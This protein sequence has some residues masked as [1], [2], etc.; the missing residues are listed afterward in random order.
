MTLRSGDRA[1]IALYSRAREQA[2]VELALLG[3]QA[4]PADATGEEADTITFSAP[5]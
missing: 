5:P 3:W 1:A 2:I 4:L